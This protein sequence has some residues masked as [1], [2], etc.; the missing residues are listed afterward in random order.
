MDVEIAVPQTPVSVT[1]GE[2]SRVEVGVHNPSGTPISVQLRVAPGRAGRW[3]TFDA[4]AVALAPGERATL[5]LAFRPPADTP[6]TATLLPFTVRAEELGSGLP[7]G[8]ATGLVG[9]TAPPRLD[10]SLAREAATRGPAE[11]ALRLANRGES[12]L[13]VRLEAKLDPPGRITV[14]PATVDIPGNGVVIATVR[15]RP[16]VP[17]VGSPARYLVSVACRDAVAESEAAPLA[18]VEDDGTVKARVGR[19]P[20]GILATTLLVVAA[21][22]AVVIGADLRLPGRDSDPPPASGGPPATAVTRPYVLVD[23]FPQ[24]DTASRGTAEAALARL[25]A[26]GMPVRLVDSTTS[27]VVADGDGG[28][29]VLLQDGLSSVDEARGYCDRYRSVA[30]KCDVVP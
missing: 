6:P 24:R 29:W 1:P 30:P 10:A 8:W 22:A 16:R 23:V 19:K 3:A 27:D 4:P 15:A 12:A 5:T 14:S 17:L 18:T 25:T 11:Y 13:T 21:L 26:A 7:A 9:V 28:L 2:E 20:A